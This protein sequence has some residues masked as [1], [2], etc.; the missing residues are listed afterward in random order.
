MTPDTDPDVFLSKINQIRDELTVLDKVVS[1]QR[2]TT[3][4]LDAL[5]AEMYSIRKLEAIR[6]PDLSL[7]QIQRMTRTI[8]IKYSE[9][10]S[11]TKKNQDSKTY[12]ESNRRVG[13]MVESQRCELLSSLVIAAKKRVTKQ[14]TAEEN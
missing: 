11:V 6:D 4:T 1:T 10:V 13:K 9:R 5:S 3:M 8:F 7:E 14:R 12:Q 2:L